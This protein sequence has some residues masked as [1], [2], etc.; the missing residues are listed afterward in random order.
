MTPSEVEVPTDML[1]GLL[2]EQASAPSAA[3]TETHRLLAKVYA[4]MTVTTVLTFA[5]L[6]T[7]YQYLFAHHLF[8]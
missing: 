7:G 6:V 3:T 5:T 4:I 2:M 1:A 8:A